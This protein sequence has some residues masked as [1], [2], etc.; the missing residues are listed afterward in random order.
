MEILIAL[1]LL[2][3]VNLAAPRFGVDSTER[4]DS[5]EWARRRD[6]AMER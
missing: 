3:L 6:R 4:V 5:P 2:A 1:A